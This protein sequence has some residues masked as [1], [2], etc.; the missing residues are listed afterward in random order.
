MMPLNEQVAFIPRILW[1]V[2]SC[3][4]CEALTVYFKITLIF[5]CLLQKNKKNSSDALS[6]VNVSWSYFKSLFF[7]SS[8]AS[9]DRLFCALP[10]CLLAP[11]FFN[12]SPF[13]NDGEFLI[14]IVFTEIKFISLKRSKSRLL[15]DI[16][17]FY[18]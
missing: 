12:V 5:S 4:S 8:I 17:R 11:L 2:Y 15:N 13:E 16:S 7:N 9:H 10:F 6:F 14:F 3:V 1:V 18:F